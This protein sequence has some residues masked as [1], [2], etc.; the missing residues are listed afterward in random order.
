MNFN[1]KQSKYSEDW[2]PVREIKGGNIILENNLLI[3]GVKITPRNIFILEQQE[4]ER[5][6]FE[7]RNFY[8]SLDFEF[9]LMVAD[10]PVDLKL[11]LSELHLLYNDVTTQASR[12]LVAQDIAKAESFSG[13]EIRAV[14]TE[15]FI[16]FRSRKE[17]VINKRI[18]TVISSLANAGLASSKVSDS[19]LK[20]IL[21]NYLN[22]GEDSEFGTVM[23]NV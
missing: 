14:D 9:W 12:K 22:G 19:D 23:A 17:E 16:I 15:Y 10:R 13:N 20:Y 6:V 4:Q 21:L 3:S 1:F 5:I 2:L 7:L 8:N 18:H 11:Y